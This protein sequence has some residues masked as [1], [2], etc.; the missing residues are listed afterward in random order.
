MMTRG[1][2]TEGRRR[3]VVYRYA[4]HTASLRGE[5][6]TKTL[7]SAPCPPS[8]ELGFTLVEMIVVIVITGIISGMVAIFINAPVQGYMDSARRAEMTDIADT[9]LRRIT[10]DLR[11]SL[12]NSVRVTTSGGNTYLEFLPT[13]GGGRYRYSAAPTGTPVCG[14]SLAA[15]VL[16]FTIADTCF[17]VLG[18][19]PASVNV[20]NQVVVYNLGIAGASAY[21]GNTAAT[22]NRRQVSAVGVNSLSITS[23]NPL[24][25]DSPGHRFQVV[26]TPVTY[27]CA[28][29]TTGSNG[30][31]SLTRWWGYPIQAAQPTAQPAGALTALLANK[32]SAC[33]FA[34]SA[35]VVTQQAGLATMTLTITESSESVNLYSSTHVSNVP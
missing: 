15:D 20:G 33:S 1:Q 3:V 12:P 23:A 31:G 32:V 18:T 19:M 24:P 5:A 10:R 7:T 35:S 17:Q 6:A 14:G 21:T 13:T 22:D 8:S 2:K 34:Y 26:T 9:A 28:P 27:V 11:L 29:S 30:S 4:A 16:N 25:F